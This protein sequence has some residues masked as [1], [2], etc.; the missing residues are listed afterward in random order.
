MRGLFKILLVLALAAAS[1]A[2]IGSPIW[3]KTEV[4]VAA[5]D[6]ADAGAQSYYS[7]HD[8][9]AAQLAASDA[10]AVSSATIQSF[11]LAPDG[12]IHVTVSRQARSYVLYRLSVLKKWYDVKASAA[13]TPHQ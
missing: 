4:T 2:E 11:T 7:G 3:S 5:R 8:L 9:G 6:A 13:A 10:A 12:Q 1:I